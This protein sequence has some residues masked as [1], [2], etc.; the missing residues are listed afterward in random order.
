MSTHSYELNSNVTNF[1]TTFAEFFKHIP[2]DVEITNYFEEQHLK[3]TLG[4]SFREII[5]FW[6]WLDHNDSPKTFSNELKPFE[7]Q[8]REKFWGEDVVIGSLL[9][10][11]LY[12]ESCNLTVRGGINQPILSKLAILATMEIAMLEFGL[13]VKEMV[14]F[15]LTGCCFNDL[16][17]T[18]TPATYGGFSYYVSGFSYYVS[19]FTHYLPTTA[20]PDREIQVTLTVRQL[21][22]LYSLI[23]IVAR[24]TENIGVLGEL[25]KAR[26]HFTY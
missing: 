4:E 25:A 14:F 3:E 19:G 24:E 21:Q 6:V 16:E 9:A 23:P 26:L 17:R 2:V 8:L 12:E 10:E 11:F 18:T 22:E 20:I 15:P 13:T 5:G 1:S 7:E